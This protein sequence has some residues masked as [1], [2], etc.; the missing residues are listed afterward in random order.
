VRPGY[1]TVD[2]EVDVVPR[3]TTDLAVELERPSV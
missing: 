3:E 1:R 2:R